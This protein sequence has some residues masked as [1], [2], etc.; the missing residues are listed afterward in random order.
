MNHPSTLDHA[1][2]RLAQSRA[3]LQQLLTP[4]DA[5]GAQ[6]QPNRHRGWHVPVRWLLRRS[7]LTTALRRALLAWW[8]AHPWRPAAELATSLA[9][10]QLLPAV[11]RHPWLAV[12]GAAGAGALLAHLRPWS[13]PVVAR[14]ASLLRGAAL[15]GLSAQ[16]AQPEVQAALLS[17]WLDA[18]APAAGHNA[19]SSAFH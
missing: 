8:L 18:Q 16:L 5:D 17:V 7:S 12:A 4:D 10:E 2:A 9:E 1:L 19:G 15:A 14:Q 11:R 13:W 3:Q 6:R